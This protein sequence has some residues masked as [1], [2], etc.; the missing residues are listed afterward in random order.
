MKQSACVLP[1]QVAGKRISLRLSLG[2]VLGESHRGLTFIVEGPHR[3]DHIKAFSHMIW[4]RAI[5]PAGPLGSWA[6]T[7]LGITNTN[8]NT[9]LSPPTNME[10]KPYRMALGCDVEAFKVSSLR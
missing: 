2:E 8:A 6:T 7:R 4:G 9:T 1:I 10:A 5:P 3:V